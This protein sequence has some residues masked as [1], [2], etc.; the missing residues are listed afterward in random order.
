M[1]N[2]KILVVEPHSDDSAIAAGAY[3][4]RLSKDNEIHFLLV[5]ASDNYLHH[6]GVVSR[7][8]RLKEYQTY[9]Q[10][11]RG[12]WVESQTLPL[13]ADSRLDLVGKSIL[14]SA[15]E[16]QIE[17]VRPDVLFVQGSSFHHDHSLTFE[18]TIASLRPTARY[19]PNQILVMENSTYGNSSLAGGNF[20]PNFYVP[21]SEAEVDE[22]LR[23]FRECFP[24]Q[25][26]PDVNSLSPSGIKAWS[27]YRG[28][29]I[30]R[31]FAEAF[32]LKRH[33]QEP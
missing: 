21:L 17:R 30:Q 23:M 14:V 1:K 28:L 9:V 3:L 19:F 12:Q 2:R 22:K 18:A 32:L 15:I 31:D 16:E 33:I 6:T 7:Q 13:D 20:S 8:T 5:S 27:R 29:E 11:L 10:R 25:H 4:T 26:R 24:S